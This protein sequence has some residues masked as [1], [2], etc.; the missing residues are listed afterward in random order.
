MNNRNR[1]SA[2]IPPLKAAEDVYDDYARRNDYPLGEEEIKSQAI[3]DA[4]SA[5]EKFVSE[6]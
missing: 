1:N 4:N 2:S 5:F 3:A 6:L